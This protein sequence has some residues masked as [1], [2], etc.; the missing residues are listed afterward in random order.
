[1]ELVGHRTEHLGGSSLL[2]AAEL[3]EA[4]QQQRL[5]LGRDFSMQIRADATDNHLG[6]KPVG[7]LVGS[8]H[9]AVQ[10]DVG[11]DISDAKMMAQITYKHGL[12][13]CFINLFLLTE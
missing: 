5:L 4:Q 9:I 11:V 13:P 10:I 3:H 6:I 2:V 12:C 1:M 8:A 7:H